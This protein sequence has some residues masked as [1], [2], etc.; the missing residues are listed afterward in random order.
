MHFHKHDI[1][2]YLDDRRICCGLVLEVDERKARV[3]SDQGKEMSISLNRALTACKVPDFPLAGPRDQQVNRLKAIARLRDDL[4]SRIDL[5]ELWEVVGLETRRIDVG[6]LSELLFGRDRDVHRE[7]SLIRAIFEDKLY[8]R[9]RPDGIEVP[10]PERVEQVLTQRDKEKERVR[11]IEES[12]AFLARLRRG[13]RL[14]VDDAPEGL[15]AELEE[16]ALAGED[17]ATFKGVKEILS[18]AGLPADWTPFRILVALGLWSEDENVRLR[19][20]RIPV[21]FSSDAEAWS[22]EAAAKPL[23]DTRADLTS[24]HLI[25]IDAPTTRDV[26]DA[27]SLT[28]EG[29]EM[30]VGIHIADAAYFVE[31]DSPLDHEIRQRAI[32]IYLPEMT[33]P[34]IPAVLSERAA[35]LTEKAVR[36][37]VSLLVRF[38]GDLDVKEFRI[39]ESI[40][41]VKERLSYE[42]ADERINVEG[43]AES[44]LLGLAE[45]VR[46]RRI[47]AGAI[48]FRDPEVSVRLGEEGTIEVARRDRETPSQVL[49]SEMMI[50]ANS[51]FASFMKDRAVPGLF[52]IQPPPLEQIELGH[53]YDPVLSYRA[54]KLLARGDISTTPSPHST[55]GLNTYTTAT[56]PLRRYTDL[57]VQ[58][59]IKAELKGEAP[60]VNHQGLERILSEISFR[61]ER[62]TLMERERQR[63]FIL[64]Y[65]QQRKHETFEAVVLHRFPRF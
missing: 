21:S 22:L 46:E 12:A 44:Q 48:I 58:R 54:R 53:G 2:D 26:D 16:A 38:G 14:S 29:E 24:L 56:S 17:W 37:A 9:I 3:L 55:L 13:D 27:I 60:P 61:M 32:S 28:R 1:I 33:I 41:R 34:M 63:Y 8:F 42:Q 52:R 36:P 59:Q 4:K 45:A 62:A 39:V 40:V 64:K 23:S 51:L 31:Y 35:S 18:E 30:I 10:S 20:E 15:V 19:S 49:V 25:T 11:F 47:A 43:S 50:L 7:A 5:R 6:D 65:L 57:I